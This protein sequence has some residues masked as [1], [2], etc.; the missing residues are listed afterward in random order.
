[1]DRPFPAYKGDAPY[2]FVSYS[3][4]DGSSVYS[5]LTWINAQDVNIWYDEGIEAGTEWREELAAAIKNAG[6]FLYFVTPASVQS[7]NCRKEVSFAVDQKIPIIAVHLVPTRLPDGLNLTLSDRQAVLKHEI[8]EREYR[9]K[10][11]SR[12]SS[13]LEKPLIQATSAKTEAYAE[14]LA[15]PPLLEAPSAKTSF[16]IDRIEH[17]DPPRRSFG[18]SLIFVLTMGA[19]GA[20]TS[21]FPL[22]YIF[23][24]N[25]YYLQPSEM[26]DT[27]S[28][29]LSLAKR[30]TPEIQSLW[31]G[32]DR[33]TR[34]A[35][36]NYVE[37]NANARPLVFIEHLLRK[38]INSL[39]GSDVFLL[40]PS[41]PLWRYDIEQQYLQYT[42][43]KEKTNRAVL[44]LMFE[45]ELQRWTGPPDLQ[46]DLQRWDMY[47]KNEPLA[48]TLLGVAMTALLLWSAYMYTLGSI[49]VTFKNIRDVDRIFE[50]LVSEMGFKPPERENEALV[51]K[52]TLTSILLYSVLKLRVT[53]DGNRVLLTA[54]APIIRR[55]S[56]RLQA[57]SQGMA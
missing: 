54:P 56:K 24:I 18:K 15:D 33:Q 25:A 27:R 41:D 35:I 48:I 31:K 39:I 36:T 6:L 30:K 20:A 5:E 34:E 45:D 42:S 49:C 21:I 14:K 23:E 52:A 37:G 44:D 4:K 32:L 46:D 26:I 47:L 50:Y 9:E 1:M 53:I 11:L 57:L 2:I 51:F 16:E 22:K 29:A 38:N 19:L 55:I 7:E 40:G 3:H 13:Y 10:L 12:I 8:P 28:M 17:L 43:E